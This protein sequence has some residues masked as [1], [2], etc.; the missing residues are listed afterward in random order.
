MGYFI[1]T[2]IAV[3]IMV[4]FFA[5]KLSKKNPSKKHYILPGLI[6]TVASLIVAI[7]TYFIGDN[8]WS[9]MGYGILFIFVAIA[10]LLGTLLGRRFSL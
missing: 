10:S 2:G 1:I 6:L 3:I 4:Y 7:T 9:N 5:S 8:P